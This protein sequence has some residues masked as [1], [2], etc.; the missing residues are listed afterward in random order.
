MADKDNNTTKAVTKQ[1]VLEWYAKGRKYDN[2][3]CKSVEKS[4]FNGETAEIMKQLHPEVTE[5]FVFK[6]F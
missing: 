5:R 1:Q 6:F 3:A 2:A 4:R